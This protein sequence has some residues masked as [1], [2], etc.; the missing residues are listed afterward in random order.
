MRIL[1]ATNLY[2]PPQGL[3]GARVSTHQLCEALAKQGHEVAVIGRIRDRTWLWLRNRLYAKRHGRMFAPDRVLG[4]SVYR[5]WDPISGVPEVVREFR[6]DVAIT[7]TAATLALARKFVE[8]GVPTVAYFHSLEF[9]KFG[10]APGDMTLVKGFAVSEYVARRVDEV[11]GIKCDV[12]RSIVDPDR[13]LVDAKR[14]TSLHVNPDPS[15]GIEITL[16]LAERRPGVV[17]DVV[18]CWEETPE[19]RRIRERTERLDNV[20]W[21][22]PV[23]DMKKLYGRTRLLLAPSIWEEAAGRVVHEAQLNGIPVLASDRGGLPESVGPGG[24]TVDPDAGIS[25][26]ERAFDRIWENSDEESEF[27]QAAWHHARR[28]EV[29]PKVIVERVEKLLAEHGRIA[30]I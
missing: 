17:F 11:L 25:E 5:G 7:G 6:P 30:A 4:Y 15:K 1:F 28:E 14:Q 12:I 9:E 18:R 20:V 16:A 22:E 8:H 26:W 3:G 23:R 29:Q 21:H 24:I 10:A 13:Y 2:Y 19:V 27:S